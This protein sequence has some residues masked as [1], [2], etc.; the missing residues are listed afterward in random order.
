MD[1]EGPIS[2]WFARLALLEHRYLVCVADA[3]RTLWTA[4]L[5]DFA[6]IDRTGAAI[7]M[8]LRTCEFERIPD[9]ALFRNVL[10]SCEGTMLRLAVLR[11]SESRL[12]KLS[13]EIFCLLF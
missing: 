5:A 1:F 11:A 2:G 10:M 9:E 7:K 13:A 8:S 3:L 6:H 4:G 12:L